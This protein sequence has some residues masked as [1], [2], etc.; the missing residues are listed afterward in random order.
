MV[1]NQFQI[2]EVNNYFD[3]ILYAVIVFAIST[4]GILL[5]NYIL[6]DDEFLNL[7]GIVKTLIKKKSG[8]GNN[9]RKSN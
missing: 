8:D 2:I 4:I 6:Y 7:K 9:E 1:M 5:I 3:W